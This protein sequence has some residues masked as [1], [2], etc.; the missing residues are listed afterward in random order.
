MSKSSFLTKKI[1]AT[2]NDTDANLRDRNTH[3]GT[4]AISTIT[5]LQ[6]ALDG[7]VKT[8]GDQTVDGIK[9]F[10]KWLTTMST[11]WWINMKIASRYVNSGFAHLSQWHIM[12]VLWWNNLYSPEWIWNDWWYGLEFGSHWNYY[13]K[14]MWT[15]MEIGRTDWGVEL[16]WAVS[17]TNAPTSWSHVVN[18]T[19]VDLVDSW[20]HDLWTS[21][22]GKTIDWNNGRRQYMTMTGNCTIT[23]SNPVAGRTYVL[24]LTQD[25]TGSR[26]IT[27]PSTVKTPWWAG[28][29]L[30]TTAN[31]KD[32]VTLYY[33]GTNYLTHIAKAYA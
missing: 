26:I 33:D 16:R 27:R 22:T 5:G 3:T 21:W 29:V 20:R 18:K 30:S 14:M 8:T 15:W 19:Y 10:S 32:V 24:E 1:I 6:T 12:Q 23:F 28:A 2:A 31:A 11:P 17:V 25:A 7:T 13:M 9:I 4:Q